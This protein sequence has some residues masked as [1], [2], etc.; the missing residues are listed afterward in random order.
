MLVILVTSKKL[1]VFISYL[2]VNV[3]FIKIIIPQTILVVIDMINN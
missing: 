1:G 2:S 3:R